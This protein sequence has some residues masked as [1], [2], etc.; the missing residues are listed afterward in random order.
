MSLGRLLIDIFFTTSVQCHDMVERH[1]DVK[2]IAIQRRYDVDWDVKWIFNK[3]KDA[4]R[5]LG[6]PDYKS[7][8][9]ISTF[10]YVL[11]F[12]SNQ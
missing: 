10:R 7:Q 6:I 1:C 3:R 2:T 11:R 9:I 4:L 8:N 5:H 12:F